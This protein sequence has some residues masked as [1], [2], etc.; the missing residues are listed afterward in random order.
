MGGSEDAQDFFLEAYRR[1]SFL[2]ADD[3]E[4]QLN[5]NYGVPKNCDKSWPKSLEKYENLC[6]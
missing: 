4:F 5:F 6:L 1:L 3:K 2:T